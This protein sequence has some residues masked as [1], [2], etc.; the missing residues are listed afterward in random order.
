MNNKAQ[1]KIIAGILILMVIGV[2][3]WIY[4]SSNPNTVGNTIKGATTGAISGAIEG[5]KNCHDE[6][7]PYQDVEYYSYYLDLESEYAVNEEKV[8][9]LGKGFYQQAQ[10]GIKNLD[11]EAGWV[12]VAIKWET[13]NDE[14][15]DNV[16]HFINPDQTIEFL[17]EF[18]V[19]FGE[20]SKFTYKYVSDPVT[21]S[22][23][24]TKYRTETVCE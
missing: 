11:T 4:F 19:D 22:R 13:L 10:I 3:A 7:I 15:I 1:V 8:E 6:Q 12:T 14:E 20:D 2:G 5:A 21:K 9:I 23:M 24:V 16:R 17:S 18:D